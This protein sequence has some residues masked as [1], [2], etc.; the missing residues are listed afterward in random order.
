M[1]RRVLPL[2]DAWKLGDIFGV[3]SA[4][5]AFNVMLDCAGHFSR[6]LCYSPP[7]KYSPCS[8]VFLLVVYHNIK[9]VYPFNIQDYYRCISMCKWMESRLTCLYD[10]STAVAKERCQV[11]IT[12]QGPAKAHTSLLNQD[13]F[14][15]CSH[16]VVHV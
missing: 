5:A 7:S 16:Y 12:S 9:R 13:A 6:V 2:R 11:V 10:T 14:S 3:H 1:R 8:F 4:T 15:I